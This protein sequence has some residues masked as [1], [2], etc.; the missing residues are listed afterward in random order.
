MATVNFTFMDDFIPEQDEVFDV[1][2]VNDH[3]INIGTSQEVELTIL[4]D[5]KYHYLGF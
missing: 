5:S 1:K 4:G 2:F 3:K